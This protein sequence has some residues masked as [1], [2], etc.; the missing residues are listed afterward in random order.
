MS[1][2]LVEDTQGRLSTDRFG[3]SMRGFEEVGSTNER[4]ARWA[5]EG[6]P[7]GATVLTEYQTTG[8]GRHGRGWTADKGRNLLFSVVLRPTLPPD[9]FGLLTVAAGVAVAEAVEGF[10]SP[11]PAALKW[12]NDVLLEGRKACGILLES[13]LAPPNTD[14]VVVLGVGLNVNQT[15]FPDALADTATSLRLA[16]GRPV[17]RSPLLA[18]LLRSLERRYDAVQRNGA[19]AV[20]STFRERLAALGSSLSLRLPGT[21][22]T[23]SGTVQ[24][25]TETGALRLRTADGVEKTVHAGEVTTQR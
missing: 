23:L 4:A 17:P 24:G 21:D 22:E 6:A 14:A 10:V 16:T 15:D 13:S 12:P 1:L 11:H 20:R 8:R 19:D 3:R 2:P 9:R 18:Q 5:A 25:I 7:E